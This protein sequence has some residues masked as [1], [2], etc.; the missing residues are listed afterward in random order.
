MNIGDKY[1]GMLTSNGKEDRLLPKQYATEQASEEPMN[2]ILT[3]ALKAWEYSFFKHKEYNKLIP[4]AVMNCIIEEESGRP[5][6]TSKI[7][8]AVVISYQILG[9]IKRNGIIPTD[10]EQKPSPM[11]YF[12][13]IQYHLYQRNI[14]DHEK[15]S[16]FCIY[17]MF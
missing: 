14:K 1:K 6:N 10:I 17:G 9:M 12:E 4:S 16:I 3:K 8:D 7:P 15:W 13:F 11:S 2:P 5:D